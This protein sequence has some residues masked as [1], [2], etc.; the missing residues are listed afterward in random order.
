MV[1]VHV[2]HADANVQTT[3]QRSLS[4]NQKVKASKRRRIRGVLCCV[5]VLCSRGSSASLT[6]SLTHS[7]RQ[8]TDTF[9]L[10]CPLPHSLTVCPELTAFSHSLIHSFIHHSFI[11]THH[12]AQCVLV[13][14]SV[15]CWCFHHSFVRQRTAPHSRPLTQ[16]LANL[17]HTNH[18]TTA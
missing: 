1:C 10:A 6:H 18:R 16:F 17:W 14:A 5:A 8:H 15:S 4:S 3:L 2:R 7:D 13:G 9:T 11:L 12:N